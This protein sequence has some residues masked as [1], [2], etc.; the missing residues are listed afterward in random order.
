MVGSRAPREAI[1]RRREEQKQRTIQE[2][3][4]Y[5]LGRS[6]LE[7]TGELESKVELGPW[8]K[9][10]LKVLTMTKRSL[11]VSVD[12]QYKLYRIVRRLASTPITLYCS[13]KIAVCC[14]DAGSLTVDSQ[15]SAL[16]NSVQK[17][18]TSASRLPSFRDQEARL[19]SYR[20]QIRFAASQTQSNSL[21]RGTKMRGH[22]GMGDMY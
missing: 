9:L 14:L 5:K 22:G 4:L 1:L 2:R 8:A 20:S 3:L 10:V 7:L 16:V 21:T 18:A 17:T 6:T 13:S 15:P 19:I 12:H 11:R